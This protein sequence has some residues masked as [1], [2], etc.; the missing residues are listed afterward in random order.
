[1]DRLGDSLWGTVVCLGGGEG[2][3]TATVPA[4]TARRPRGLAYALVP[5]PRRHPTVGLGDAGC[6]ACGQEG[7]RSSSW[8][9]VSCASSRAA[10]VLAVRTWRAENKQSRRSSYALWA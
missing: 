8:S 4:G 10:G 1:M 7:P 3:P 6:R 9:Q 2:G 5:T